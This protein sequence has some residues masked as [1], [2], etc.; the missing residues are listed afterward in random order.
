[1]TTTHYP[2]S[3]S[4]IRRRRKWERMRSSDSITNSMNVKVKVLVFQCVRLF[5]SPWTVADQTSLLQGVFPIQGSNMGLLHFRQ[6]L[7]LLS[8]LGRT[9]WNSRREWRTREPGM[10]YSMGSQRIRHNLMTGQQQHLSNLKFTI[11]Y[12]LQSRTKAIIKS[13][14]FNNV[15]HV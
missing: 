8:H 15:K 6:I 11:L 7:Y 1:M 9:H 5:V 14:I 13:F 2:T 10:L 12:Y 3:P 4:L